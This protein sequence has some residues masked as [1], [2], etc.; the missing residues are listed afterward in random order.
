MTQ[1]SGRRRPGPENGSFAIQL[2]VQYLF[3]IYFL[4]A[5]SRF[6]TTDHAIFQM[7]RFAGPFGSAMI[8]PGLFVLAT[9]LGAWRLSESNEPVW[10]RRLQLTTY[11]AAITF[12]VGIAAYSALY[13]GPQLEQRL[14]SMERSESELRRMQSKQEMTR[15]TLALADAMLQE[16]SQ[17]EQPTKRQIEEVRRVIS[18]LAPSPSSTRQAGNDN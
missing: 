2:V 17:S 9:V 5:S 3:V 6:E 10:R 12:V 13:Q 4:A 15:S 14:R 11:A 16:A 7:A 1:T 18:T 8:I